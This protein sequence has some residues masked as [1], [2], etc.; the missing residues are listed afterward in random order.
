MLIPAGRCNRSPAFQ[1]IVQSSLE[2]WQTLAGQEV[3]PAADSVDKTQTLP[4]E[5]RAGVILLSAMPKSG[6]YS[7]PGSRLGLAV[8]ALLLALCPHTPQ[9]LASDRA[10]LDPRL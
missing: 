2:N 7:A 6:L 8:K 4:V 5:H 1:S 9:K 3:Q 10:H